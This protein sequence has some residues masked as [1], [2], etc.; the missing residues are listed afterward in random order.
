MIVR[1][2]IRIRD[3]GRIED[4]TMGEPKDGDAQYVERLRIRR[5]YERL[6]HRIGWRNGND[7]PVQ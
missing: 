1:M 6:N 4:S 3:M 7:K 5:T 2:S